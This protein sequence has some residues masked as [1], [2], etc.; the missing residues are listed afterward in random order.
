MT[1]DFSLLPIS[2][3]QA[4]T[5]GEKYFFTGVSC[6]RGHVDKRGTGD[7]QCVSCKN[8][9]QKNKYYANIDL[10]RARVRKKNA[11]KYKIDP[12]P[13][14]LSA[15]EA[16][17]KHVGTDEYRIKNLARHHRNVA[18]KLNRLPA[19]LTQTDF[20][21]MEE[22]FHLAHLRTNALNTPFEVDHILPL[23]GKYVSGLHV[24]ANL[25]VIP[26][27]EN[28]RKANNFIPE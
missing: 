17:D 27:A 6:S 8:L 11:K 18:R 3:K 9:Y 28:K 10:A 23:R 19:W 2:Q 7:Y 24:P 12:K 5:L 25:Q 21:M 26:R 16:R 15:K 4:K 14:K 1:I 20:W 13:Q 22:A